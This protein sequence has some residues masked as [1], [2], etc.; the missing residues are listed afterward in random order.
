MNLMMLNHLQSV[1]VEA[2]LKRDAGLQIEI[3]A[4]YVLILGVDILCPKWFELA[5]GNIEPRLHIP[6]EVDDCSIVNLIP[7]NAWIVTKSQNMP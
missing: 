3:A 7:A 1:F 6:I 5:H 2:T 4:L